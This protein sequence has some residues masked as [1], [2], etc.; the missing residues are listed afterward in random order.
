MIVE[1]KM[2][3][4]MA[5]AV[6]ATTCRMIFPPVFGNRTAPPTTLAVEPP[7][8]PGVYMAHLSLIPVKLLVFEMVHSFW[9]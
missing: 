4:P 2:A 9:H 6:I 3:E 1:S 5:I 7:P 8:I